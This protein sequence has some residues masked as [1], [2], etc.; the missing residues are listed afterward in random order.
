MATVRLD[1]E[2]DGGQFAGW[3][4]QP[5]LRTVEGVLR[6]ALRIVVRGEVT[7]LRVAGRTDAGVS[8]S[9]QVVSLVLPDGFDPY[10]LREALNGT[11]PDDVAIQRVTP[12]PPGF[13]ARS[14]A[15]SRAYEYRLLLGPRS[16]LRRERVLRIRGVLDIA[17]MD[18]AARL[19]VGQHTFTA[20]TPKQTE[21]VFFDRT[22]LVCEWQRRGDE[23]VFVV[24]ANAFLRNMVRVLAGT[25]MQ[26]GRG[27]ISVDRYASLL[28]GAPREAAGPT[29]PP[30]PLTLVAV[31]YP[32][33]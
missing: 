4:A 21:H 29:A 19:T 30:H 18:E 8:A 12:A 7:D 2:Y 27:T 5:D 20:F 11:L 3:A 22:V 1:L 23:L 9:A 25:M 28:Q 26:V 31:R 17:A 10:R 15:L 16:P 6:D 14:D 33:D 13:D 32:P 24:E